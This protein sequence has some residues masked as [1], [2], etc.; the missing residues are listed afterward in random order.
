MDQSCSP[1]VPI[2]NGY[3]AS[4]SP[5]T[6]CTEYIDCNWAAVSHGTQNCALRSHLT[7]KALLSASTTDPSPP[8]WE[9]WTRPRSV[10]CVASRYV[11]HRGCRVKI[12]KQLSL[13]NIEVTYH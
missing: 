7:L 11:S 5:N 2:F 4:H 12:L 6:E 8:V 9:M 13:S 10:C 1:A 3:T